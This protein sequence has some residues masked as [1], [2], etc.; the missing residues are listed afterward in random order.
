[1]RLVGGSGRGRKLSVVPGEGTRPIMDRVKT[2]LFDILRPRVDGM[3][4]LDLF[5]GSGAVG[6]EALSQGAAGCTFTEL[7]LKAVTTIQKNLVSTGMAERARVVHTDAF[8]FLRR[9]TQTFDL[10]YVAPPQYKKLW[11]EAVRIIDSRPEL[12]RGPV[13]DEDGELYAGWV[14]VQIHPKEYEPLELG[15]FREIR[16]KTYGRTLLVFYERGGAS[17]SAD[18]PSRGTV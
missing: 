15:D 17:V 11:S 12:V 4:M 16:Q 13:A 3:E 8:D 10:I 5:A 7:G 6:I 2:S 18:H 9:T 14:I 1:M